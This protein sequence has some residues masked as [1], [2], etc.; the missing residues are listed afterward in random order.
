M[1]T[2]LWRTSCNAYFSVFVNKPFKQF[3]I[4]GEI[5]GKLKAKRACIKIVDNAFYANRTTLR[6]VFSDLAVE[7]SA[8]T[9]NNAYRISSSQ[10]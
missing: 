2:G 10:A 8:F 6:I 9:V 3:Y 7:K 4:F 5:S 1:L